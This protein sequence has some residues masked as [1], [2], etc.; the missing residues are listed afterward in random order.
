MEKLIANFSGATRREVLF[1]REHL[2]APATLIV[3]GVL[4]GSLGPLL[5]PPE[6][7]GRDPRSWDGMPLL[8]YHPAEGHGRDPKVLNKQGVGYVFGTRFQDSKLM[9]DLWFDVERTKAV[10]SRVLDA[11][12]NRQQIE[13]STGL[14]TQNEEAESGAAFNSPT[15]QIPYT[16][17]A[18]NYKPDH[19][20]ILPDQVGACSLGDGC[21]VLN[22]IDYAKIHGEIVSLHTLFTKGGPSGSSKSIT[23]DEGGATMALAEK[24]KKKIVDELVANSCCWEEDDRAELGGMTDNQLTKTKEMSDKEKEA[25]EVANAAQEGF[26]SDRKVWETEK[27]ELGDL[28]KNQEPKEARPM[29][30]EDWLAQAPQ[31]VR[32]TLTH[33]RESEQNEKKALIKQITTN[34][35]DSAK[36]EKVA[37]L[38]KKDVNELREIASFMPASQRQPT[39][40]FYPG[41]PAVDNKET[42]DREDTLET[43]EM[44]WVANSVFAD[45]Q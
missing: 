29:T 18:R 26:D 33:A 37:F 28:I 31:S 6:E 39:Q 20:A 38:A 22:Q 1:G 24:E 35:E 13:L 25:E 45:S 8:V 3:P 9:A 30:E 4:N 41:Q 12:Q 14:G 21:G 5:Y 27:A 34:V 17:I 2:V 44:D 23:N 42:V 32:N 40:N 43:E 19:L 15:G 11:L 16:H 7:V 36:P 10:D